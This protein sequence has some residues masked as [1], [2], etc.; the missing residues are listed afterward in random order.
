MDTISSS[1]SSAGTGT[2]DPDPRQVHP[3]GN[4]SAA[5]LGFVYQPAVFACRPGWQRAGYNFVKRLLDVAVALALLVLLLPAMVVVAVLVRASGTGPLFFKQRR[6]GLGGR[7]FWCVKF[8]TMVV[9]A[10]A[11]LQSD[12]ELQRQFQEHYKLDVDPRVTPVGDFLRRTSLDELPQLV[13]V[14]A[15][16]MTLIGPRPIV[17]PEMEKYGDKAMKLLTVKP[18]LSGLWQACGRSDTTY[19][20]RVLMDMLYIDHRS[21]ALDLQLLFLTGV[22]VIKRQGAR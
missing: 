22:A 3:P 11:R 2:D 15:G 17:P 8:R 6:L 7:E 9:D 4:S 19:E 10:E 14:L 21:F 20:E 1:V 13:Q 5:G 18:G 16:D 12:P